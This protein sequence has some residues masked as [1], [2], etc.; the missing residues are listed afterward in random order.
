MF[1]SEIIYYIHYH[2]LLKTSSCI[3]ANISFKLLLKLPLCALN[4][5]KSIKKGLQEILKTLTKNIHI[6]LTL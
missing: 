3:R 4:P 1:Q 5:K 6:I 2:I